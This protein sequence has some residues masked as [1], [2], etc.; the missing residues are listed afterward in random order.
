MQLRNSGDGDELARNALAAG[1]ELEVVREHEVPQTPQVRDERVQVLVQHAVVGER[2]LLDEARDRSAQ[3]REIG[4][5]VIVAQPQELEL[6][7][8]A[9]L[10]ARVLRR[11]AGQQLGLELRVAL[12]E[13]GVIGRAAQRVL[14]ANELAQG[15]SALEQQVRV[16]EERG[17]VM[18]VTL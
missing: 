5:Q 18:W 17:C 2:Q 8:K 15:L 10:P 11:D 4:R 9:E 16:D 3:R 14:H 6:A 12:V 1:D 7:G 13:L